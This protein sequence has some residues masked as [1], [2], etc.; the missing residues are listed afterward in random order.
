MTARGPCGFPGPG[1]RPSSLPPLLARSAGRAPRRAP[2]VESRRGRGRTPRTLRA[3]GARSAA[4]PRGRPPSPRH[5]P[6]AP[7]AASPSP[8][9]PPSPSRSHRP[10]LRRAASARG[11]RSCQPL[12]SAARRGPAWGRGGAGLQTKG[13]EPPQAPPLL[14]LSWSWGVGGGWN[15]ARPVHPAASQCAPAASFVSAGCCRC[16][17]PSIRLLLSLPWKRRPLRSRSAC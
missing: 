4:E 1:T 3:G 16:S 11:G 15:S 14:D 9:L 12:V 2:R 8:A 5:P 6:S 10:G 13:P 7:P 17:L